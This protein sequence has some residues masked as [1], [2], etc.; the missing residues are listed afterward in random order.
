M[1]LLSELTK[2]VAFRS[3]RNRFGRAGTY[4]TAF[5]VIR[6]NLKQKPKVLARLELQPGDAFELHT[7][8][9]EPKRRRR[10]RG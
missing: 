7:V 9:G 4:L 6:R 3:S 2:V 8:Q 5:M 10:R 1:S